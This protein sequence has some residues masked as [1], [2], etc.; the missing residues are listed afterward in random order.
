MRK[1]FLSTWRLAVLLVFIFLF[2][3]WLVFSNSESV[4]EDFPKLYNPMSVQYL[5][6]NL[7]KSQPRLVL[8]AQTERNLRNKLKADPVVQNMYK[9]I[10]LNAA[11][12]Q[13]E[14]LLERIMTGR[15]L[16]SVSREMLYRMNMLGMVC[17]ALTTK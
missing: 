17:N 15:R 3:S 7:R 8:N 10:Q 11:E 5:K 4:N 2:Q 9:A 6:E 12:I 13:N 1:V 16:L 14:P